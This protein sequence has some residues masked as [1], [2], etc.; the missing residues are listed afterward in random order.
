M[1]G[2]KHVYSNRKGDTDV[3]L[4]YYDSFMKSSSED[5]VEAYNSQLRCGITGVHRQALYLIA[6]E[7][8]FIDRF[9]KSPLKGDGPVVGLKN[10]IRLEGKGFVHVK[11]NKDD[12]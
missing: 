12:N 11:I 2:L 8:A 9:G 4:E 7:Q 3:I 5:L 1:S 10:P 6:L